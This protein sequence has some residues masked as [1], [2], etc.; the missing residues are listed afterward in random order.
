[1]RGKVWQRTE[2]GPPQGSN[3]CLQGSLQ[4]KAPQSWDRLAGDFCLLLCP[5]YNNHPA[6]SLTLE[7]KN[8][9]LQVSDSSSFLPW[10]E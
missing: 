3:T 5:P 8:E 1:M 4:G 7:P 2:P 6:D 9:G 10:R